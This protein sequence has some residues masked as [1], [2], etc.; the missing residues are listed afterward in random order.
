M[1]ETDFP[2]PRDQYRRDR[3]NECCPVS[4]GRESFSRGQWL[5][6]ANADGVFAGCR[7]YR[8]HFFVVDQ[9]ADGEMVHRRAGDR[10]TGFIDRIMVG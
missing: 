6:S 9:Q 8:F 7:F 5:E 4:A 1:N 10:C 2:V 3:D